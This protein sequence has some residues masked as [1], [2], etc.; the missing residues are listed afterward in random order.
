MYSYFDELSFYS[1]TFE[2]VIAKELVQFDKRVFLLLKLLIEHYPAHC[3]KRTCLV[4]V[5]DLNVV[6]DM[7]SAKLVS[8]T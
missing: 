1:K 4:I 2:L 3:S 7:L 8:D 6:S 5:S